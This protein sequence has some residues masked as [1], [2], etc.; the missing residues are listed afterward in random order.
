MFFLSN[1][2]LIYEVCKRGFIKQQTT[3]Y[4]EQTTNIVGLLLSNKFFIWNVASRESI[5]VKQILKR[6]CMYLTNT[7][8]SSIYK[9]VD[10]W[11]CFWRRKNNKQE[12]SINIMLWY[13][14]NAVSTNMSDLIK[15]SSNSTPFSFLVF[16][17]TVSRTNLHLLWWIS[18]FKSISHK[19]VFHLKAA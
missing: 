6:S 16:C 2:L 4:L 15:F 3:D 7:S 11:K 18:F 10:T 9:Y 17:H 19:P 12:T 14:R 8:I 5:N 13:H 1:Y